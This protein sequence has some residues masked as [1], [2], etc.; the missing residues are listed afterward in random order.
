MC[1][2]FSSF[3]I[4][5]PSQVFY[6]SESVKLCGRAVWTKSCGPPGQSK[7]TW[8]LRWVMRRSSARAW[9]QQ[10]RCSLSQPLFLVPAAVPA[11][12][13][14]P[15]RPAR[16]EGCVQRNSASE[17]RTQNAP[18]LHT[19]GSLLRFDGTDPPVGD[20]Q[21]SGTFSDRLISK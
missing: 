6:G 4:N 10:G 9:D 14:V 15:L 11:A 13:G 8:R 5:V 17:T 18:A 16:S 2:K 21:L 3:N 19:E 1:V 20:K 7:R 12:R